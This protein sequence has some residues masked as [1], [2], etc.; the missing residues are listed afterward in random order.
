VSGDQQS[1]YRG[2][3]GAIIAAGDEAAHVG[4]ELCQPYAR[5][6]SWRW[7]I[8]AMPLPIMLE[9]AI[10]PDSDRAAKII[11][12]GLGRQNQRRPPQRSVWLNRE[13]DG[14]CSLEDAH[15]GFRERSRSGLDCA[16]FPR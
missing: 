4:V 5:V 8:N 10:N 7:S 12:Q 13:C 11:H 9:Q 16:W 1:G 6:A 15:P 3:F 14:G 2:S